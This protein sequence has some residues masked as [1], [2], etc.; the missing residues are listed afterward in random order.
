MRAII[1]GGGKVGY[2]LLKTLLEE[3]YNV[4]LIEKDINLCNKI[5]EEFDVDVIHGD[6]TS[7]EVLEEA[8]IQESEIVAAV[9]GKDEENFVIC[10]MV[11][12][13]FSDKKTIARINNPKNREIFK[14]LGINDTVCSTEVISTIIEGELGNEKLKFIQTLNRGEIILVEAMVNKKSIL[15]DKSIS[16]IDL[17]KGCVIVSIFREDNVIYP[18][19]NIEIRQDDRMLMSIPSSKKFELEKYI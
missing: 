19:G 14:A 11:K 4:A 10:Q 12:M 18:K 1:V 15:K 3:N 16:S 13:N 7:I 8:N 2:Y 6:G 5:A 17:P 9:T